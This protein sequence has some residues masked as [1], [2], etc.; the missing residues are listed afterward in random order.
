MCKVYTHTMKKIILSIIPVIVLISLL[1][2]GYTYKQYV[3]FYSGLKELNTASTTRLFILSDVITHKDRTS[4]YTIINN[5]VYDLTTWIGKH[6]GG[7][8]KILNI[9]G[10]DGTVKF[11][12]Q[13]GTDKSKN[14]ILTLFQIGVLAK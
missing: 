9:C 8:Q 4:C 1:Y 14:D 12:K 10:K 3:D 6:P 7:E 5:D 13:H 11:D 2:W